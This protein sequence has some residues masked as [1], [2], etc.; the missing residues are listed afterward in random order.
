[1]P[2]T[3]N[4]E[5]IDPA[6][7]EQEFS[8]IKSY[9]ESLGNVSC[10][11]RDGEFRGY[12]RENIIA[13]VLLAQQARSLPPL[14][15]DVVEARFQ[16]IIAES[17]GEMQFY[18]SAGATPDQAPLLKADLEMNLRTQRYVDTACGPEPEPSDADLRTAYEK[19]LA[20]HMT[21][22][23]ARAS[24]ILKAPR[25]GEDRAAAYEE[26]RK[27]RQ[28]ILAGADFDRLALEHSDKKD[29]Q[30]DLG[31][32]KR[33]ELPEEFDTIA[34]SMNDGEVSPVFHS[35]FGLH[36]L[37][38]TGRRGAVAK[39]FDDV[40]DAVRQQLIQERRNEKVRNLVKDLQSKAE[41][42]D[43]TPVETAPVHEHA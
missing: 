32:F 19:N 41:I 1:M 6:V 30:V 16:E 37:K 4:G 11:E 12:A 13:R 20:Q 36:L 39:P 28:E 31:W 24:H 23:E 5:A 29:E 15:E 21:V 25:R 2:L 22:E 10:C 35:S 42:T 17:G 26:L 18:A 34:F 3:I 27:V 43:D 7:L 14:T 9:F 8:G 40:R 38:C 33:A